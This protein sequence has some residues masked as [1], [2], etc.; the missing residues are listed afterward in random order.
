LLASASVV[1]YGVTLPW[2]EPP[3]QAAAVARLR[4]APGT[5]SPE[6]LLAVERNPW[7][8]QDGR[9]PLLFG[10]VTLWL[11]AAGAAMGMLGCVRPRGSPPRRG[12]VLAAALP[13]LVAAGL[14]GVTFRLYRHAHL[15]ATSRWGAQAGTVAYEVERDEHPREGMRVS[16]RV[17][18]G[19][20]GWGPGAFVAL[21]GT[22]VGAGL[23][24][25]AVPRR[26]RTG[27]ETAAGQP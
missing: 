2:L 18:L 11:A 26:G 25:L 16:E 5:A 15:D 27:K 4:A 3:D 14:A 10:D 9:G 20:M 13:W 12:V 23:L 24:L 21:A 7:R 22:L 6:L 19:P 8:A 17:R 1:A